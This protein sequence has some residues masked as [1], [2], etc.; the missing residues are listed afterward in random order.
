[1]ESE[2]LAE[3]NGPGEGIVVASGESK[4]NQPMSDEGSS[5]EWSMNAGCLQ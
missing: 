5:P 2:P 3:P 1:M 4:K